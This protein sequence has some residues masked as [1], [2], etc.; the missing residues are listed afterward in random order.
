MYIEIH[1]EEDKIERRGR[2]DKQRNLN[3][4]NLNPSPNAGRR[5]LDDICSRLFAMRNPTYAH[6]IMV[7]SSSTS[8]TR[9]NPIKIS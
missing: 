9:V 6:V 1:I 4:H 8:P 5:R 2:E 7:L 3:P